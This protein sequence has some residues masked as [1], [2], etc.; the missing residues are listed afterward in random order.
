M[1]LSALVTYN[2]LYKDVKPGDMILINDGLVALKVKSIEGKN[3]K[4][5]VENTGVIGNHKG[6]EC[7]RS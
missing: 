1:K 2:N 5:H 7:S 4:T 3:I 6:Y